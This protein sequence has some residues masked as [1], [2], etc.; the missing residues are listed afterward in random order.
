[1]RSTTVT[2]YLMATIVALVS[3]LNSSEA[4]RLRDRDGFVFWHGMWH[5][6]PLVGSF[7]ISV[8]YYVFGG[9]HGHDKNI[10]KTANKQQHA[11]LVPFSSYLM[12]S[13]SH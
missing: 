5:F 6:Y 7:I 3:F 13:G 8:D 2:I 4:Q 12:P 11:N 10:T 1:M 9:D